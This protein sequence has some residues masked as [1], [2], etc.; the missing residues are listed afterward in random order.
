MSLAVVRSR[1]LIGLHA[2]EVRVEVHLG[3]GL[4]A[5]H[6]VGLPQAAVRE[7]A[8]RVR[9]ALLHC[10]F[11]FPNRR[12][13]VN[14]APADLPKDSGRFDLPIAVGILGASGQVPIDALQALEFV[15]EL[16]LT[17]EIR[18]IRG[19]LAMA[20]ALHA[21][22]ARRRLVANLVD[23]CAHLRGDSPLERIA[24]AVPAAAATTGIDFS[25][26]KGQLLARRAL[27]VAAAGSHSALMIGPPGAGKT[28]LAQRFPGLL[29]ALDHDEALDCALVQSI[30]GRFDERDWG[31]RPFRSPHHTA[32]AVALVG[33]GGVPRPGEV[34]LAHR[35][36][37]FLDELPEFDSRVL[38]A[39]REPLES[40]EITISRAARQATFPARFQLIAAMNPCPCGH[41]G[42]ADGQ[43]TCSA[44][45]ILRYQRSVSGPLLD[46]IDIRIHVEP[47]SPADLQRPLSAP[48]DA[49]SRVSAAIARQRERQTVPNAQ[50]DV[51]AV[52]RVCSLAEG[53]RALLREAPERLGWSARGH[54]RVLRVART[55]ADL[56]GAEVIG[57]AHLAEAIQYRRA[58]ATG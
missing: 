11:E 33:G 56:A 48:D 26:V 57:R 52:E 49:R 18:P 13:T 58:L 36:V 19:A 51:R 1:A 53:A 22:P 45:R 4:P 37:L 7:S 23:V 10:G 50:L 9:A 2:P 21:D 6:I 38:E 42:G 8:D 12:L 35:G 32:S 34:T 29:P 5:F 44:D 15:G 31:R 3:N 46:R 40:G 47:V 41:A 27:E 25:D 20:L 54:H 16:S 14:L 55:I 17:G 30:A 28:M 24:H 43:C 39:L